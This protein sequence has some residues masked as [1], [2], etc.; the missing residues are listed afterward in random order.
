MEAL[1]AG[2]SGI[3]MIEHFDTSEYPTKFAGLVKDFNAEDYMPKKD[4]K[5]MDLFI[6]YGVA[7]GVQAIKDAGLEV[8]ETNASRIGVAVGSGIGGLGLIE[9]NHEKNAEEWSA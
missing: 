3:G 9:E 4:A 6:Q 2:K 7:A 1:L 5:K 8:T